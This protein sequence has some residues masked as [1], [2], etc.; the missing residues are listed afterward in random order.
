MKWVL[1]GLKSMFLQGSIHSGGSR[2]VSLPV[3]FPASGGCLHSLAH[4]LSSIFKASLV[5]FSNLSPSLAFLPKSYE[6]PCDSVGPF[7]QKVIQDNL[8]ISRSLK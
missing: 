4:G 5:A 7:H 3:L 1:M 6:N 2:G 8:H